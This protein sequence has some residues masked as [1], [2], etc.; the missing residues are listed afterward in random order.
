MKINQKLLG[1][2]KAGEIALRYDGESLDLLKEVTRFFW[3]V[4]SYKY[5]ESDGSVCDDIVKV[6]AKHVVDIKDFL[7][8]EEWEPKWGEKVEVSDSGVDW[9]ERYFVSI[10][11]Q[12]DMYKYITVNKGGASSCYQHIRQPLKTITKSEAE[13]LLNV[14]IEG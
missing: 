5:Y 11:P 10:N 14:K 2:F 6:Q 4:G 7:E 1:R 13:K 9:L 12:N 8:K 3:I